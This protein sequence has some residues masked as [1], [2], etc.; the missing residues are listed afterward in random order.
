MS[1]PQSGVRNGSALRN[2]ELS[3]SARGRILAALYLFVITTGVVAQAFIANGMVVT[4]DPSATSVNIVGNPSLYRLAFTIFMVE[5]AAQLA[6][7]MMF[8]EL[9]RPVNRS[10]ARLSAALGVVASGIKTA[11]RAF[12]YVPLV[13]LSGATY[14]SAF[15]P[16]QLETLSL[17]FVRIN[18]QIAAVALVFF[19]FEAVLRG[20]LIYRSGFLPRL[21]GVISMIGGGGWLTYLW[22]PLGSRA[23]PLVAVL[24][25]IGVV[26]TCG[27]LFVRGVDDAKWRD[28]VALG[29]SSV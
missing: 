26:I 23:F 18:A 6:T 17:V 12:F 2:A 22:P 27:W 13:L 21:L 9:L 1:P 25:L 20:W 5:M 29:S 24:A 8:Y 19:G 16:Q 7:T 3:P 15:T 4:N 28:R 14:L 11:A 10:V